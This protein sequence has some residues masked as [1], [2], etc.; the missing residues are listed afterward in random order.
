MRPQVAKQRRI[1]G[2]NALADDNYPEP[3][4]GKL[5][6]R[7][8]GP[9]PVSINRC[10]LTKIILLVRGPEVSRELFHKLGRLVHPVELLKPGR[11]RE[12]SKSREPVFLLRRGKRA[13]VGQFPVDRSTL[14]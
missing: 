14:G 6:R 1:V 2:D 13:K 5:R 3:A 7:S 9:Q 4:H 8:S 12:S 11:E 10:R